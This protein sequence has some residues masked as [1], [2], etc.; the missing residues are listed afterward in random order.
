MGTGLTDIADRLTPSAPIELTFDAQPVATGRKFT[1]IIGHKAASGATVPD[2]TVYQVTNVGNAAAAVAEVQALAGAGAP[3][4][5]LVAA[6]INANLLAGRANFPAFRVLLLNNSETAFGT[7]QVALAAIQNLRS[8]MIVSPYPASNSGNV[9]LLLNFVASISGPDRDLNGQFGSFATFGSIDILAT[10]EA[11]AIN[12]RG[13]IVAYLQDTNTAL[14]TENGVLTSGSNVIT[15]LSTTAGIYPGASIS[16]TGVPANAFAGAVGLSTVTMVDVN[17]APLNA[18]ANEASEA[19]GFQN[20]V[21]Q[22]AA[23]VAAGHAGALMSSAFP[24]FPVQG[25]LIGGLLPPK[26]ASDIIVVDPN[27]ASE[28]ALAA[29]LSPLRPLPGGG[30]GFIRSRTTYNLLPDNV[31]A[32]TAYFD[33]QDL[34]VMNDF[35]ENCYQIT[36]NPPF[37]NNP[38]GTKASKLI[39]D[40]LKDEILREAQSY[41]DQGAFQAVKALAPQ[42]LVLPSTSSR[43]RFDFK[44]PVNVLPG[45]FVIAGNIQGTTSFDF[46]L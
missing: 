35:R 24:Y 7:S 37:N 12:S 25:V 10:A 32:A 15:S 9:T 22:S 6:F 4:L 28:A 19:I 33:W 23:V 21:S 36:Q 1:T 40:K 45:L 17:G 5:K 2:N 13:G 43:G 41:E 42:F 29:G 39:A 38:G 14:V 16:G 30:I 26:K 31:T 3:I 18:A 44:I 11:Y 8:D 20:V 34:V 46:S 27:G